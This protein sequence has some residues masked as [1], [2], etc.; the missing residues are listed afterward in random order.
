MSGPVKR[1][2]LVDG[3]TRTYLRVAPAGE[4][5]GRALVLVLHGSN[6][7]ADAI[8]RY[9]DKTFDS[10]AS[11]GAVVAYLD[12]FRG[13]WND[14]RVMSMSPARRNEVDDVAFVPPR[15]MTWPH[16][17]TWIAL[18]FLSWVSLPVATWRSD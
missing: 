9:S 6:Q 4:T 11:R 14:A 10:L 15:S 13:H 7:S 5:T 18:E 8:R 2:I 17:T 16:R 12:G 1:S 3:M